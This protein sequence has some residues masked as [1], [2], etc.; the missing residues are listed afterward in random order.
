MGCRG[1][2]PVL[3]FLHAVVFVLDLDFAQGS[4]GRCAPALSVYII[5]PI[6]Y[7]RYV[8]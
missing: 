3:S 5:Y 2:V 6:K 7:W 8:T 1:L 4:V